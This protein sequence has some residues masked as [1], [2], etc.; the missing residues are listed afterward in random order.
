ML[1]SQGDWSIDIEN[2]WLQLFKILGKIKIFN[3]RK[4]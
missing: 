2:A 3:P 1:M 4:S